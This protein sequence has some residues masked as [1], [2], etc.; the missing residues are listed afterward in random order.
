MEIHIT[1]FQAEVLQ[2][3]LAEVIADSNDYG[4]DVKHAVLQPIYDQLIKENK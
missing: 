4:D 2:G 3:I 1:D